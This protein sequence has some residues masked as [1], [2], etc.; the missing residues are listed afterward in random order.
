MMKLTEAELDFLR[1][2][3]SGKRL[4]LAD[5][6]QDR[7]RQQVRKMQLAEVVMNPRRW[8]LTEAGRTALRDRGET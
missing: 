8:V 7:L 3:E 5:R 1:R 2:V 6:K 4:P